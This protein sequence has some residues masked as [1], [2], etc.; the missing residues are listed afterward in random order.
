MHCQVFFV[1]DK[2][3]YPIFGVYFIVFAIILEQIWRGSSFCTLRGGNVQN[4]DPNYF[5]AV[6]TPQ[7]KSRVL[8]DFVTFQVSTSEKRGGLR[9][10]VFGL[11]SSFCTHPRRLCILQNLLRRPTHVLFSDCVTRFSDVCVEFKLCKL[12]KVSKKSSDFIRFNQ[13]KPYPRLCLKSPTG[14]VANITS[15]KHSTLAAVFS[16]T[17]SNLSSRCCRVLWQQF[18]QR[19][20]ICPVFIKC[21]YSSQ[22]SIGTPLPRISTLA[23]VAMRVTA[24]KVLISSNSPNANSFLYAWRTYVSKLGR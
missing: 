24:K 16:Q 1:A 14:R 3:P 6:W 17:L 10:W 15:G 4:E 19:R 9:F 13:N 20:S 23:S 7:P 2:V 8:H 5:F 21:C 11:R 18:V 12:V 22:K